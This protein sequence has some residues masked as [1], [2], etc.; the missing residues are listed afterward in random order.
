MSVSYKVEGLDKFLSNLQQKPK[1]VQDSVDKELNRSSLRVELNAKE[2]APFETGWLIMNIYSHKEG[3]LNYMVTSPVNY[4]VY[5]EYGTRYMMAQPFMYP[6]M[7]QEYPILMGR[8]TK[9]VG[10]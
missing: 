4:S 2:M 1:Q 7:Q 10:G 6:A 9:I 5:L 3:T 8:L